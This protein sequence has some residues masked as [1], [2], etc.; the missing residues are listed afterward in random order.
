MP[1]GTAS[2]HAEQWPRP[3]RRLLPM[4]PRRDLTR[5]WFHGI[6]LSSADRKARH[7]CLLPGAEGGLRRDV[8]YPGTEEAYTNPTRQRGEC[9]SSCFVNLEVVR[10][11][12]GG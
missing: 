10:E 6:V 3:S 11:R 9:L 5:F 2:G 7:G 1:A 4:P 8:Y 12:P